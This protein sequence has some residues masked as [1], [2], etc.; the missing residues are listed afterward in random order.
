M[1][2][3]S[4]GMRIGRSGVIAVLAVA[5]AALSPVA[6][7][8]APVGLDTSYGAAGL[9]KLAP[10]IPSGLYPIHYPLIQAVF[11]RDGSAYATQAVSACEI[12][13][14][15]AE[16]GVRLFHYGRNGALDSD[17]R[18]RRLGR[19]LLRRRTHRRRRGRTRAGGDQDRNRWKGR[20]VAAERAA[21][22]EL[23]ARRLVG[24]DGVQ[25]PD[26]LPRARRTRADSRRR[27]RRT[28]GSI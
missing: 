24:S 20:A 9:V 3:R 12:D 26:Q 4:L 15:A 17:V 13:S 21:R 19:S 7:V 16:H 1:E 10:P 2:R 18:R 6:A 23:R 8:A 22:R 28:A 14:S 11:A 27:E 5:G 25:R